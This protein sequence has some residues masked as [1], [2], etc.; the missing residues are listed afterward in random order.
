MA[1]GISFEK[2]KDFFLMLDDIISGK[3]ERIIITYKYRLS[4]V[5]FEL[6]YHYYNKK[7]SHYKEIAKRMNNLDYTKR[8]NKIAN[9]RN[10]L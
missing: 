4:R 1:S 2:R 9:K 3:V 7:V 10:I 8:I 5:G 6:F